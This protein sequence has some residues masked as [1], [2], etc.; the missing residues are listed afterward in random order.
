[1]RVAPLGVVTQRYKPVSAAWDEARVATLHLN[2][3]LKGG[4]LHR[5]RESPGQPYR[6]AAAVHNSAGSQG[7]QRQQLE[8][9]TVPAGARDTIH[10]TVHKACLAS[11]KSCKRPCS[12]A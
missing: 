11:G 9:I 7:E 4:H 8:R 1:M 3:A 10:P 5:R 6:V 12:R 2:G